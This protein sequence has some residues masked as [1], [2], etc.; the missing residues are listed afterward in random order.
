MGDVIAL[1]RTIRPIGIYLSA[2]GLYVLYT[3][4]RYRE[5]VK[6]GHYNAENRYQALFYRYEM[7]LHQHY[8]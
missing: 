2:G 3:I 6:C 4:A 5:L 8:C 7:I 1:S